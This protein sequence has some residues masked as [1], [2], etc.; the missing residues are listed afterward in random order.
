[1]PQPHEV[2]GCTAAPHEVQQL[3]EQVQQCQ[4]AKQG[5]QEQ[6]QQLQ[7]PHGPEFNL[8][9]YKALRKQ[10]EI[11]LDEEWKRAQYVVLGLAGVWIWLLTTA[12]GDHPIATNRVVWWLVPAFV[13]VAGLLHELS[14]YGMISRISDYILNLE[15]H[16]LGDRGGWEQFLTSVRGRRNAIAF[17]IAFWAG[18][19]L[20]VLLFPFIFK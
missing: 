4:Q 16:F 5:L 11:I 13:Y 3:R 8:E 10:I 15:K 9:E 12:H 19:G 14:A 1:M 18:L 2:A 6:V 17:K 20:A 7:Q